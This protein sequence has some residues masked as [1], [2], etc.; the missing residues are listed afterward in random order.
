MST[1]KLWAGSSS[2]GRAPGIPAVLSCTSKLLAILAWP[3]QRACF[4][5]L[6]HSVVWALWSQWDLSSAT[7]CRPLIS[8][9]FVQ[10]AACTIEQAIQRGIELCWCKAWHCVFCHIMK[11]KGLGDWCHFHSKLWIKQ[12]WTCKFYIKPLAL[13]WVSMI[14]KNLYTEEQPVCMDGRMLLH[15]KHLPTWNFTIPPLE[16]FNSKT[17]FTNV[18]W[19]VCLI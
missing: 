6:Q 3:F 18:C 14:I 10:Y 15:K 13:K 16:L 5:P 17:F 19:L 11:M 7:G 9:N 4:H 12:F 2:S 1:H 8:P